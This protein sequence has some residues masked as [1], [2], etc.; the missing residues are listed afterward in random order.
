MHRTCGQSPH[1]R[2]INS[3]GIISQDRHR[4]IVE[5][6]GFVMDPETLDYGSR[7]LGS[8]RLTVPS[9]GFETMIDKGQ[10]SMEFNDK[11]SDPIMDTIRI[12]MGS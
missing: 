5:L 8:T 1:R 3:S 4:H 2:S 6:R 11:V 10:S 12:S 7:L 9:S